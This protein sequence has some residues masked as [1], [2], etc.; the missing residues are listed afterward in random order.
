MYSYVLRKEKTG[1][2]MH[3]A[4]KKNEF[5][6]YYQ[7]QVDINTMKIYGLEALVRWDHPERGVLIPLHFMDT[8][9]KS[10]MINE[11]G[12]FVLYEAC[13]EIRRC[14]ERGHPSLIISVNICPSQFEDNSFLPFLQKT[15]E[16]TK[17]SPKCLI[18]EITERQR[19]IPN[20]CTLDI[21]LKLRN[22]GIKV[23]VDDFGT[24]YSSLDYLRQFVIDGIKIDKS[25]I[26]EIDSSEKDMIITKNIVNLAHELN[27]EVVAEG[28]EREEQLYSLRK[29]NCNKVQGFIFSKPVSSD[30]LNSILDR[31]NKN[32]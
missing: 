12:K 7:P 17:V 10:G 20:E 24:K 9:E 31:F 14:H 21:I 28:V 3:T 1:D 26:D 13:S 23:F 29:I 8:V 15:L 25:F 4:L 19:L 6:V 2:E 11:L 30:K 32:I 18:F 5:V 27:L 22:M 16:R